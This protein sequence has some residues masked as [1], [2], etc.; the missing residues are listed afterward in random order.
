M[1]IQNER[2]SDLSMSGG[3][4][5]IFQ[6]ALIMERDG[7][8]VV[9]MEIGK[10]DYDSPQIAKEA[11]INSLNDGFV[12]YTAMAGIQELREAILEKEQKANCIVADPNSEIIVTAGA[13]EALMAFMLA[14]LDPGDEILI[15]SP[16]FSAYDDIAKIQGVVIKEV[17]L[18]FENAFELQA[19]DLE[20]YVTSKTK[21]L[22]VNT[23]HN[24]TGAVIGKEELLK[25]AEFAKKYD[26]VVISDETYDQFLFEGEHVSLYTLPGMK[27]RTV[28][29]NSTSKTFSMTGWRVGYAIGPKEIIRY[30]NKVHQNMSTCA[31]SFV[32]VGAV[33]A[34][35][36][37]KS[38]TEKMVDTFRERRDLVI[39]GLSQIKGMEYQVPHG[40]F[41]IFPKISDIGL[42][43]T[44]FCQRALEETGVAL[45]PGN[46]FGENGEGFIRLAYACSNEEIKDA[47]ALLK[48]F[49]EEL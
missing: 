17:P 34:F 47:M 9:H 18:K 4:Y 43:S 48:R 22:L 44:E 32:Q 37:G 30:M 46:A 24:P 28:V 1:K 29:I 35:Q 40:A 14:V 11:V 49:V 23:P 38:F 31:T 7:R 27:E 6:Q 42:S 13:C 10:P 8:K 26:L 45:V 25:I 39:E 19:A 21:A 15:P 33:S 41:Y 5:E 16:Y 3:L 2:M 12:H 20:K 36:N